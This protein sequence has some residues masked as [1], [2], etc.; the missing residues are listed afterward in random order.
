MLDIKFIRD[1]KPRVVKAAVDKGVDV[2]IEMTLKLDD[3]RRA[4]V[5]KVELPKAAQNQLSQKLADPKNR[6]DQALKEQ[7]AK[8]KAEAEE[9][10]KKLAPVEIELEKSLRSIPNLATDDTP[11]GKD[12][13]G[14]IVVRTVG[15]KPHFDFKPLNHWEIAETRGWIDKDRASK[16][17]GARFVYIRGDLVLLQMAIM[18]FT[19]D[20]LTDSDTIAAIIKE[21]QL[22]IPA[23]PFMPLL[24]PQLIRTEVFDAMDRLEPRDDRYKI[25]GE[26]LWLQGSAEHV[27]GSMHLGEMIAEE[28]LPL[29]YVGYATSFRK[30]AGA[31]GKDLEGIIR[32]HQFDKLE[33]ETLSVPENG[34]AEHLLTIAVQEHMLRKLQLPYHVLLKCTADIGKP[35]ARGVDMEVWM[36]GQ[37][38]YRETHTADYMTD[39]QA[40]RLKTRVKRSD[41]QI[42]FVHTIDAT[43]FALGRT[44]VAIIENFQTEDRHVIIPQALRDYLN[45]RALL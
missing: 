21:A 42:Q 45:G 6:G 15:E 13:T 7:A 12:E 41:G 34:L 11:I 1:N 24:P 22:D 17:T 14:N 8:L 25:E 35:N 4:L 30:E 37:Q 27:I 32:L 9:L 18:K 44:M 2:D 29:R 28:Q 36:P 33:V 5:H 39:Y 40:R 16:V 43:A 26:E 20:I 3:Q 38:K 31:Y 23:K 10:G 19:F